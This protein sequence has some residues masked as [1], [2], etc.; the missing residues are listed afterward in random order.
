VYIY[1]YMNFIIYKMK[2]SLIYYNIQ[3]LF[4]ILYFYITILKKIREYFYAGLW[5]NLYKLLKRL[6]I[7]DIFLFYFIIINIY[8]L[9]IFFY[10][11]QD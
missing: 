3:N 4:Q 10:F 1:I 5:I 7:Y 6:M 8:K 2:I 9:H 11:D